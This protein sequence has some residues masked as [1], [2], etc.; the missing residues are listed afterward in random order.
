MGRALCFWPRL[1]TSQSYFL[2]D[3]DKL[4][5]DSQVETGATSSKKHYAERRSLVPTLG[6]GL[7]GTG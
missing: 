5:A 7:S 1:S 3:D 6:K 4:I 2:H